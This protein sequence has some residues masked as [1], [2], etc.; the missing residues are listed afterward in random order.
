MSKMICAKIVASSIYPDSVSIRATNGSNI[1]AVL[2]AAGF[3]DGDEIL[4]KLFETSDAR[5]KYIKKI[6]NDAW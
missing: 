2:T 1:R 4:I 5:K 6:E 3:K